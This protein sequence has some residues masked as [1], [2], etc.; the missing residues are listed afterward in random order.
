M[1]PRITFD[2]SFTSILRVVGVLLGLWL[3]W[4]V[5]D[6]VLLFFVVIII[7][8][9]LGPIVDS[10]QKRMARPLA[11]AL[12]FAII[13]GIL[14]LIFSLIIPPLVGQISDLG[15]SLPFY[16]QKFQD[17]LASIGRADGLPNF[18]GALQTISNQIR[19][20]SS[21]LIQT[22]IGIFSGVVT[23]LTI[24]V[25]SIYLLLDKRGIRNVL[26][27]IIP[28]HRE[29][30]ATAVDKIGDK[31]GAWF[32][33]QLLLMIII[34]IMASIWATILGLPF[35]LTLGL[36]AGLTEV[37]PF[38]G[39][40]IGGIPI[41]FIA[42]LDS[43]LKA[44]IAVILLVMT[45]QIEANIIVPKVMQRSVGLSPVIVIAALLIGGKVFGITGTI[46]SVPVAA[47]ISVIIQEW[48]RLSKIL[49]KSQDAVATENEKIEI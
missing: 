36:W 39:P 26:V 48:P 34:G 32:R 4:H 28:V 15:H 31:L 49:S 2:I 19:G 30:L 35:A 13:L 21:G 5:R 16:S 1:K 11:V 23:F 40:I 37:I 42:F 9:A 6:I 14:A 7:V 12:L 46:L 47:T 29:A 43:P 3:L 18:E 20:L 27:S 24:I 38:I 22:T 25:L 41:I 44:L 17:S 8:M 10:W 33:G 45:Q